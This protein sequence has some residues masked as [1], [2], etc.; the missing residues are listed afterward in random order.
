MSIVQE[1]TGGGG[2]G[3]DGKT[4]VDDGLVGNACDGGNTG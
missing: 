1:K 4:V 2:G 3:S